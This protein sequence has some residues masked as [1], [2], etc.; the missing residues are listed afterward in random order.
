MK[1]ALILGITSQDGMLLAQKLLSSGYHVT[2]TTRQLTPRSRWILS[3]LGL[4]SSVTIHN[5]DLT[6]PADVK[7]LLEQ[8]QFT[9]IYNLSAQSSV[10]R[11]FNE[12]YQTF[13]SITTSAA[14]LLQAVHELCLDSRI[15]NACS[16]DCFG[17]TTIDHP[18]NEQ[19]PFKPLSPYAIAKYSAFLL[20]KNFRET[21]NL[22]ISNGILFNHESPLRPSCFV[23]QKLVHSAHSIYS[24]KQDYVTLGNLS[25][26]RDWGWA[27]EYVEAIHLLLCGS[28]P[29]DAVIAT[30]RSYSLYDFAQAIFSEFSLNL[31][32][33]LQINPALTR[34]IDLH[35]S[36]SCPRLIQEVYGW[37][38]TVF[39]PGI[40]KRLVK[41]C[42]DPFLLSY[43]HD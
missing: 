19:S 22:Y 37:S 41:H 18:F 38:A 32:S 42:L 8:T 17:S 40:A 2:G 30:G 25:V 15:F 27:S 1:N 20:F 31:D 21:H 7:S 14:C 9:E 39:V 13:D 34:P 3:Q 23:S 5:V 6:N 29:L 33:H 12:P 35:Q 4:L 16:S 11:S 10:S 43:P 24:G 28:T 36:Y 26:I